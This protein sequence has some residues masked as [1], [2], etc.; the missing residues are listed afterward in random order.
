MTYYILKEKPSKSF[1]K[2]YKKTLR[3]KKQKTPSNY[4]IYENN[5][6][7]FKPSKVS[8]NNNLKNSIFLKKNSIKTIKNTDLGKLLLTSNTND[9][10]TNESINNNIKYLRN[11][12]QHYP[13][14]KYDKK[15]YRCSFKV[16]CKYNKQ[17]K[18]CEKKSANYIC[19]RKSKKNCLKLKGKCD[20][21]IKKKKCVLSSISAQ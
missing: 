18:R 4:S 12:Y 17:S 6:P 11:K 10:I 3:N 20:W 13:C 7:L 14:S 15:K 16:G 2:K 9:I 19:K 5:V 1:Y 8:L 21:N